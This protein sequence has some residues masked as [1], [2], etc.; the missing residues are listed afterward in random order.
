MYIDKFTHNDSVSSIPVFSPGLSFLLNE[1]RVPYLMR[2]LDNCLA[3]WVFPLYFLPMWVSEC[4]RV[5][6]GVWLFVCCIRPHGRH[7]LI[8]VSGFI[9]FWS[10]VLP[11]NTIS[12]RAKYTLPSEWSAGQQCTQRIGQRK[13]ISR[14]RF[15]SHTLITARPFWLHTSCSFWFLPFNYVNYHSF[16]H[17]V[18]LYLCLSLSRFLSLSRCLSLTLFL[19]CFISL[20]RFPSLSLS[21]AFSLSHSLLLSL[22]LSLPLSLDFT[23]FHSVST[24]SVAEESDLQ[25]HTSTN[26][27][28]IMQQIQQW[29]V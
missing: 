29:L 1:S 13:P 18:F 12:Q 10:A 27:T 17:T 7:E 3:Y 2:G 15:L 11:V 6:G 8:A 24:K 23:W 16:A 22:C 19:S 25:H 4:V 5:C 14:T 21:L 26:N 28:K 20:S 9:V